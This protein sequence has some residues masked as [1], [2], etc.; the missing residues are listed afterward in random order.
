MSMGLR[1]LLGRCCL[2]EELDGVR[3]RG[4]SGLT[5]VKQFLALYR[6]NSMWC[7]HIEED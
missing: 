2:F 5:F 7:N 1:I 4:D 6:L 3:G